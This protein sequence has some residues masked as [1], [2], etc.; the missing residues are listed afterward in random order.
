[1]DN[2]GFPDEVNIDLDSI[3]SKIPPKEVFVD[4]KEK[5][6]MIPS[7]SIRFTKDPISISSLDH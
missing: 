1:M 3:K 4:T 5:V 2:F 7:G 6:D